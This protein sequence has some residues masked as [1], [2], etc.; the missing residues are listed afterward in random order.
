MWT[1]TQ[2]MIKSA[3]RGLSGQGVFLPFVVASFAK[4]T[5]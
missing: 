3:G 5:S 1:E 2:L 4:L